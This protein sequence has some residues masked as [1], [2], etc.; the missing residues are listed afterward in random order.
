M[1]YTNREQRPTAGIPLFENVPAE[2][3]ALPQWVLWR[4]IWKEKESEGEGAWTKVP[5]QPSGEPA[6]SANPATW[7]TF[8]T[9][10]LA[11][12]Q[13]VGYFSG[14]GFVLTR[15]SGI[16]GIDIDNCVE[17]GQWDDGTPRAVFNAM[18]KR[19]VRKLGDTYCEFSPSRTGV[20]FFV[21]ANPHQSIKFSEGGLEIY[22]GVPD[23]A[24]YLTITGDICNSS[25]EA[26]GIG[27]AT[28]E[29]EEMVLT[30]LEWRQKRQENKSAGYVGTSAQDRTAIATSHKSLEERIDIAFQAANGAEIKRLY[31]GDHSGYASRSEAD[32]ALC[33]YLAFY[34]EGNALLLKSLMERSALAR[35]K[36]RAKGSADGR[37]K[38]ELLIDKVLATEKNYFEPSK[39]FFQAKPVPSKLQSSGRSARKYRLIEMGQAALQDRNDPNAK[40]L[41]AGGPWT[42]LDL[43]FRPRRRLLTTVV[44]EPGSGKTTLVLNYLYHLCR[45]HQLH[46]GLASF[47]NDAID[48]THR[49][50]QAHL[51]KPTYPEFDDC[52]TEEEFLI[53][54]D[55]IGAYFTVYDPT[56]EEQNVGSLS[57]FWEDSI[58]D[59]GLDVIYLDPFTELQPPDKLLGKYNEFVNQQLG[60]F[61]SFI[62]SRA[63]MAWLLCHP[64]KNYSRKDGL[65]LWNINGSGDFERKTDFGL[66]ITRPDD[67][68]K[69]EVDVQKARHWRTG[70]KGKVAYYYSQVT[71][72]YTPTQ[73]TLIQATGQ[74]RR[75][76]ARGGNW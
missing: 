29:V 55:Q 20:H 68:H 27:D 19:V 30:L 35:D 18:F 48:L 44:G 59:E 60:Q 13:R 54:L 58:S 6:S 47:E 28:V 38:L 17:W 1:N 52:C 72:V 10:Q 40:G 34:S 14:I 37:S 62:R 51:Q 70:E 76:S 42:E 69:V 45:R 5:V 50:V 7:S 8:A 46:A 15:E 31:E 65:R 39:T 73:Q 57:G 4:Y 33:R 22:T 9:V 36:W 49:L 24:R 66:V 71:G 63:L 64:T 67:D 16:V 12:N 74:R 43:I 3:R 23:S 61:V 41:E 26:A 56:W 53:A 75:K 2:L 11:Y 21:K 32:M 25:P